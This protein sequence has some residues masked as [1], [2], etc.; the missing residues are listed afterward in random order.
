[1]AMAAAAMIMAGS[2]ISAY[3]AI[4]QANAAKSAANFNATL[5]ERDATNALVSS[6]ENAARF[7]RRA[8]QDQGSLLAG[9]GASG[10]GLEGSPMDVLRMSVAN[11]KL[12]EGTILYNGR[13]K[14]TGYYDDAMLNRHS[15]A[16]AE[17]QGTLNAASYL[18]GGAGKA[19]AAYYAADRPLNRNDE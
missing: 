15:G 13:L 18:I 1:M 9:Y 10:V 19:G 6:R 16:V 5:R 3:G 14:S 11:A 4:Q 8:E 12:D 7:A 17:Q 2:A